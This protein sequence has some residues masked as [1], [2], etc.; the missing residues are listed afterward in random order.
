MK[1]PFPVLLIIAL[2]TA[3]VMPRAGAQEKEILG[4]DEDCSAIAWSP[5]GSRLAYSIKRIIRWRG[6]EKQR[7]DIWWTDLEGKRKRVVEGQKLVP[8]YAEFSYSIRSLG[9]APDGRGLLAEML[10]SE[11][12]T[13]T[14]LVTDEGKEVRIGEKGDNLVQGF[15][16]AWLGDNETVAFLMEA[17]KPRLL[18]KIAGVRIRGGRG[19]DL[20]PTKSFAAVSWDAKQSSAVAVQRE[21][22]L[23]GTPKLVL[24]QL[25]RETSRELAELTDGFVGGLH[26][27]PSG[28][29]ASYF[30]NQDTFEIRDL[31]EPQTVRRV[32]IPF[33]RYEWA[34]DE[35][36]ILLQLP[37]GTARRAGGRLVWVDLRDGKTT[38]LLH[39]VVVRD[40]ALSP[41]GRYL[42]ITHNREVRS[43]VV[44]SVSW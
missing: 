31:A 13:V 1:P 44:Y 39:S 29:L 4:V 21:R 30:V 17:V 10:T 38:P 14:M 2:W 42:A 9:W 6:W 7:D 20:F 5:D 27:S 16:A 32:K 37:E 35:K 43:L 23:L 26:I 25:D 18:F 11:D 12:K 40:F 33:G 36:R 3:L 34:P 22:D 28:K 41:S 8:D 19:L 24:L 15:S